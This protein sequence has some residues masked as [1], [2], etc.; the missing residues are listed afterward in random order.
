MTIQSPES[1][2]VRALVGL[3]VLAATLI[4]GISRAHA[5]PRGP[6]Q[7]RYLESW[8]AQ[9]AHA[10]ETSGW[11]DVRVGETLSFDSFGRHF[12]LQLE[13]NHRMIAA[14][15]RANP[16]AWSRYKLYR[17]SV[18]GR[19]GS[20]LRLMQVGSEWR[21]V[22]WDGDELYVIETAQSVTPVA[23]Q[24][25]SAVPGAHV[26]YR[27]SDTTSPLSGEFCGAEKLEASHSVS[28]LSAYRG[29][30]AELAPP[31][32]GQA[33]SKE[34]TV[35]AIEDYE[36]TSALG[37][38]AD[39]RALSYLQVVDG[40]FSAQLGVHIAVTT[41]RSF[42]SPTEPFSGTVPA[43]LLCQV[44]AYKNSQSV[45]RSQG[46]AHLFTGRSL[47]GSTVGIAYTA[48]I[49]DP[50]GPDT[51]HCGAQTIDFASSLS[52]GSHPNPLRGSL[53]PA[54]ALIAAH[55]IG[56]NFGA[57]HDGDAG[58]ACAST[59][60]NQYLMSTTLNG[61]S[62]LSQCSL[63][64]INSNLRNA[65]CVAR[66]DG[67]G[68]NIAVRQL[69]AAAPPLA[70]SDSRTVDFTVDAERGA[71]AQVAFTVSLTGGVSLSNLVAA[72]STC[73]VNAG[74]CAIGTMQLGDS[75]TVSATISADTAGP[76]SITGEVQ[77]AVDSDRT[78]DSTQ[79]DFNVGTGADLSVSLSSNAQT[80]APQASAS[81]RATVV[82]HS[83]IDAVDAALSITVPAGLSV[84]APAGCMESSGVFHCSL[85]N[86][87][88]GASRDYD[89]DAQAVQS[90]AHT[91]RASVRGAEADP[92]PQNDSAE[93]TFTVATA[94][95]STGSKKSGGGTVRIEWLGA[96]GLAV[97]LR[98]LR[99][100]AAA[101]AR[102]RLR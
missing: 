1:T 38:D 48:S 80:L 87:A 53:Y 34:L 39:A 20:W 17:G 50:P 100:R 58:G 95:S 25:L 90:G 85:G 46:I 12:E 37:A 63:D 79:S 23:M 57:V 52:E 60:P 65:T 102:S 26:I 22:L 44:G 31:M 29:L 32:E 36:F 101:Q 82:N 43:T 8:T 61:S 89:F 14:A 28:L 24:A 41:I 88:A 96:M 77:A 7:I 66:Y 67:N 76:A 91:L 54:S 75:V 59:P 78:D 83:Q 71:N 33:A 72:G 49:C 98:W 62:T 11:R 42:T 10:Q 18:I 35:A 64:S 73:D 99:E 74:R 97:L 16:E 55:E 30:A 5:G 56:H 45:L 9:R 93:L 13:D 15:A 2:G 21:G 81:V 69:A 4:A 27:L 94:S 70:L 51:T 86:F 19:S 84:T 92:A 40:I 3:A 68:T 47:D 6:A